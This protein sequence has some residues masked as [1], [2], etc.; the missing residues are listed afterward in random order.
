ELAVFYNLPTTPPAVLHLYDIHGRHITTQTL[1]PFDVFTPLRTPSL[2]PGVYL[3]T[4]EQ[5]GMVV[6]RGKV[7]VVR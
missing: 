7:A 1:P 2:P 5:G 3:Y 4:A 6:A